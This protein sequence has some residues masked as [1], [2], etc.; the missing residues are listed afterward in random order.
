M[1]KE[2]KKKKKKKSQWCD[3]QG[4]VELD[5]QISHTAGRQTL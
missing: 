3:S 5:L 1:K 4:K 2:K